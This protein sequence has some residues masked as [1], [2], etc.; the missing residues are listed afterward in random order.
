[1]S[2]FYITVWGKSAIAPWS[3]DLEYLSIF[4]SGPFMIAILLDIQSFFF[5]FTSASPR[6]ILEFV[7]QAKREEFSFGFSFQAK[8]CSF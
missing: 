7:N 6:M 8:H 1:M 3:W 2:A 4:L 5:Q